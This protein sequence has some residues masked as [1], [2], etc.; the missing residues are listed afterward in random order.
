[1]NEIKASVDGYTLEFTV[2]YHALNQD[3]LAYLF[4]GSFYLYGLT[5]I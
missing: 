5:L 2:E 1:M 4:W 3:C